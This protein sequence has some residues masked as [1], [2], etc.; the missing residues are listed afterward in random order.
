MAS[1]LGDVVTLGILAG[2]AQALSASRG[3]FTV[4]F[5][6]YEKKRRIK[7]EKEFSFFHILHI[8]IVLL[9]NKNFIMEI[10]YNRFNT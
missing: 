2:C 9:T 7:S 1:S 3:K 4:F 6:Y 10:I 8:Y 5:I